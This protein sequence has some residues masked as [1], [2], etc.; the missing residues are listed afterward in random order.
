NASFTCDGRYGTA[1]AAQTGIAYPS[2]GVYVSEIVFSGEKAVPTAQKTFT[3]NATGVKVDIE[4]YQPSY[5]NIASMTV[6]K[7]EVTQAM[8]DALTKDGVQ[9]LNGMLEFAFKDANGAEVTD[10]SAWTVTVTVPAPQGDEAVYALDAQQ[11][12]VLVDAVM[13]VVDQTLTFSF[14]GM[15]R[16]NVIVTNEIPPDTSDYLLNSTELKAGT[17]SVTGYSIVKEDLKIWDQQY[18]FAYGKATKRTTREDFAL[19]LVDGDVESVATQYGF[20]S[21]SINLNDS[22]TLDKVAGRRLALLINLGD[23]SN[24]D[25]LQLV[26]TGVGRVYDCTVYGSI[27]GNVNTLMDE[28]NLLYHYETQS[29]ND[30]MDIKLEKAQNIQY[31]LLIFNKLSSDP[32]NSTAA[33][34]GAYG[35]NHLPG[36]AYCS[37]GINVTELVIKG[38]KVPLDPNILLNNKNVRLAQVKH[39]MSWADTEKDYDY[40]ADDLTIGNGDFLTEGALKWTDGVK[41]Q[42]ADSNE[43]VI[44]AFNPGR[45]QLEHKT[46]RY[47]FLYDLGGFYNLSEIDIYQD[48]KK[49]HTVFEGGSGYAIYSLSVYAGVADDGILMENRVAYY[50]SVVPNAEIKLPVTSDKPFRYVLLVWNK[51]GTDPGNL[52]DGYDVET[53]KQ[54]PVGTITKH[55]LPGSTWANSGVFL[56]EIE[57]RGTPMQDPTDTRDFTDEETGIN[58]HMITYNNDVKITSMQ[59]VKKELTEHQLRVIEEEEGLFA[60]NGLYHLLFFDANGNAVTDMSGRKYTI[61]FPLING[62]ET[63]YVLNSLMLPVYLQADFD[64]DNN[65]LVYDCQNGN[66]YFDFIVATSI[67]DSM[68]GDGTDDPTDGQ[69]GTPNAVRWPIVLAIVTSSIAVIMSLLT[70]TLLVLKKKRTAKV[71]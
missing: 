34:A 20:G 49:I 33:S 27:Y 25:S 39:A 47:A 36:V 6:T 42:A 54:D 19:N 55:S 4:T 24:I 16:K 46:H 31:L 53:K 61:T 2:G 10:F 41:V 38:K 32:G 22:L 57:V 30:V 66:Y 21:E 13:N 26:T 14:D 51:M 17:Q 64:L 12:P 11:V 29:E 68:L 43:S 7:K 50:E 18:P 35:T 58:V 63:V 45:G 1:D 40:V 3:D 67:G 48:E 44:G 23:R 65:Q 5:S 8:V 37:G 71:K 60:P 70:V 62:D 56:N 69:T 52:W 9:A 28:N 15:F 59:V